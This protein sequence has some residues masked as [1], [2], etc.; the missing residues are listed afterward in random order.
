MSQLSTGILGAVAVSMVCGAVQFASGRDLPAGDRPAG[1]Q[2]RLLQDRLEYPQNS[3]S[4]AETAINRGAKSDRVA[5]RVARVTGAATR[6]ISL[7]LDGLDDTSMLVRIPLAKEV[8]KEAGDNLPSPST[9]KPGDRKATV[10]CEPV[11]SVLTEVAKLLQPGRCV[12]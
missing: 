6:T 2:D 1:L 12:T 8:G 7:R 10:A 3:M 5:D 11:V 4:A 9:T